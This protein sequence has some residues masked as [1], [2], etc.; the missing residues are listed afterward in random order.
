M[1]L[2]LDTNRKRLFPENEWKQFSLETNTQ[3][4]N[5][6]NVYKYFYKETEKQPEYP[7]TLTSPIYMA[8]RG[9]TGLPVGSG[10]YNVEA[11][12]EKTL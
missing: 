6:S 8:K 3:I 12:W 10:V 5:F 4:N 2:Q 7:W 11:T 1:K 9:T